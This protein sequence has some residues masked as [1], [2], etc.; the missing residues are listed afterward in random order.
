MRDNWTSSELGEL[1]HVDPEQLSSNTATEYS[2]FYIDISSVDT[3]VI[4]MPM[5]E[6]KY[7][8]SPSRARKKLKNKDIL[9][10]TVRPNLKSFAHFKY[11]G[12]NNFIASTGFAVIREKVGSDIEFIYHSL[13]S[14]FV[15]KQIDT[16]VVGSNYPAINSS[17]VRK[18]EINYPP[19]PQ[20]RKIA[21]ILTTCDTVIKKTEAAIAKYQAAHSA[22]SG[23]PFRKLTDTFLENFFVLKL[24]HFIHFFSNFFAL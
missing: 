17:D 22:E 23:H 24:K 21:H 19:L 2:F 13:F 11:E 7:K 8:G 12:S 18:L 15:E 9:M 5:H 4:N 20:Q 16:L 1:V 10:S 14:M 3:G 6:I